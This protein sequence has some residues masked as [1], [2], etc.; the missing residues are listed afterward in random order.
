MYNKKKLSAI[1]ILCYLAYTTIY[2]ARLNLSLAAPVMES[3]NIL[4]K[5]H[6][7]LMGSLFFFT[8]SLGQLF[9]GNLGDKFK[10]KTMIVI[11]LAVTGI[12]NLFIGLFPPFWSI[13]IFW[14]LNGYAQ[15]MIWGPMLRTLSSNFE[16]KK[17]SYIV[18]FLVTSVA[19]GSVLG[20][21]LAK[22]SI[23]LFNV[24]Y[25]FYI[26]GIITLIISALVAVF[27]RVKQQK[28][29]PVDRISF[30]KIFFH[31]E[32]YPM[33]I[34]AI[35]HGILKDNINLW[36]PIY[37]VDV[38]KIDLKSMTY[39]A[40]LIPIISLFGRLIYPP[41]YRVFKNENTL[42][43]Y[44]F[45]TCVICIVP[46]C[47]NSIPPVLAAICLSIIAAAISVI[48][49]SI[50]SIFPM[51]FSYCGNVSLVAGV[52]DFATYLGAGISSLIYGI[53]LQISGYT[54]MYI[55]WAVLSVISVIALVN[56]NQQKY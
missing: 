2:I 41:L 51:K 4:N 48:N 14:G 8:Y 46:L 42:S 44:A 6:I 20:I 26:P 39:F 56:I 15:S 25:A 30:K 10:P 11:G 3:L 21:L 7:G 13:L 9:N 27:L 36:A 18:S 55:S 24:S 5:S 28:S 31:K 35:A 45:F 50:L 34:P 54:I 40:V 32:V 17:L 23:T 19:A 1:F 22:L 43:I 52:M 38:Y 33:L 12:C 29:I 49:T 16:D 47:F 53:L 37:F